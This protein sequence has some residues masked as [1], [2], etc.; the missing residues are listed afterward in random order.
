VIEP[1]PRA[2]GGEDDP[3]LALVRRPETLMRLARLGSFHPTRLSFTRTLVRRM[4]RERWTFERARFDVDD[5]GYGDVVYTAHTP[6]RPVHF[7]AFSSYLDP[8]DRTDRVIAT[9]WDATFAL[10]TEEPTDRCLERLRE[11]VPRQEAGRYSAR[12]LVLSRANRS[13]RLFD[14][15][16]D[17]LAAGRQPDPARVRGVGYLM[18][19][20]AVYGNGK[21]G[22]AD[23]AQVRREGLFALP[24]QAEMLTVFLA[25]HLSLELAQHVAAR[26]GGRRAVRL[27][28]PLQRAF[29]VGNA[30]GLGMAPFLITHPKLIHHWIRAR[31]LALARVRSEPSAD[32]AR[33]ERFRALLERVRAHVGQWRTDDE[34]QS[35]RI[36]TLRAE[37][38]DVAALVAG[39]GFPPAERPW[40]AVVRRAEGEWSVETQ[41]LLNSVLLELCP[42][43]VDAL[44]NETACDEREET[45]PHERLRDLKARLGYGYRWAVDTDFAVPDA[46]HH[47]WYWSAEKLEPRLGDRAHEP[48][49]DKEMRIDVA[50]EAHRLHAE[51]SA[52]DDAALE[53]TVGEFLLARPHWRRIVRRVQ[54]LEDHPYA[55]IRDNILAADCL[56]IDLLRCKLSIFGASKFDPKSDRWTRITL[57]QGAPLADE[58]EGTGADDWCFPVV[59]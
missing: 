39:G 35:A 31:E 47:F 41:E 54:S 16:V 27:D 5:A 49:A 46:T 24:F 38:A 10:T 8:E 15:V 51:L 19:T 42:E 30:T 59:P 6:V 2:A 52:L 21:F 58:L 34:R 22:L 13:V 20:T 17:R 44:E 9:R 45:V 7:V 26:R 36:E 12:E 56:P 28:R 14:H 23:F 50:R 57:F 32:A 48:G 25:R 11:N 18:R 40:D 1:A 37:L 43:R 3:A 4:A 29:G 53:Q 33:R 55:E